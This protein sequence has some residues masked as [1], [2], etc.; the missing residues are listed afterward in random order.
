MSYPWRWVIMICFTVF[1]HFA[2]KA[3]I[4]GTGTI[5]NILKWLVLA[6]T[7]IEMLIFIFTGKTFGFPAEPSDKE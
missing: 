3:N 5:M 1:L 7:S 4:E 6:N 2:A